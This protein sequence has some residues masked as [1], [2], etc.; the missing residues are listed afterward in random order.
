[1]RKPRHAALRTAVLAVGVGGLLLLAGCTQPA[2]TE[3]M[4]A[5]LEGRPNA[6]DPGLI[7]S[8]SIGEISRG[9][10]AETLWASE[11]GTPEFREALSRSLAAQQVL[12]DGS[13]A[14]R[15]TLSAR[16]LEI[17]QPMIELEMTVEARVDYVLSDTLTGQQPFAETI[18][19]EGSASIGDELNGDARRRV[20]AE[21]AV[22][23]N[24]RQFLERLASVRLP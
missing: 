7:R 15:Y 14:G 10:E 24:I 17:S 4:V 1:M 9:D 16:I 6:M 13:S 3:A 8:V 12:T 2:A 11:I 18:S 20:A 21:T 23:N 19:S 22:R 5:S